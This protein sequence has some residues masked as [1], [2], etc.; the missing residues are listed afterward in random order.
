MAVMYVDVEALNFRSSPNS[1][2]DNKIG[3]LFLTQK[4]NVLSD[5]ADGWVRVEAKLSGASKEGFVAKRFLRLPVTP[6]REAL[7][8]S[9]NQ[10]FMR[11]D[12]GLGKENTDPFFKFV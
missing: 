11:F 8:A 2:S 12:R 4:V 3:S 5:E 10:Q 6:H 7:I 1:T 9:V